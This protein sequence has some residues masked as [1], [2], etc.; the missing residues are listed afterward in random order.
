MYH[1]KDDEHLTILPDLQWSLEELTGEGSCFDW[2]D[3]HIPLEK[4]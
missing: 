4:G 2:N 3:E 1:H